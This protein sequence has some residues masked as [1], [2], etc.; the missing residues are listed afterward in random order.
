MSAPKPV[1]LSKL[2]G[3]SPEQWGAFRLN[4]PGVEGLPTP[5]QVGDYTR[6]AILQTAEESGTT[7]VM[8]VALERDGGT[9]DVCLVGNSP[10][11]FQNAALIAAAPALLAELERCREVIRDTHRAMVEDYGDLEGFPDEDSVMAGDMGESA[12]TFGHVR[13]LAALLPDTETP[14]QGDTDE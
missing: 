8:F 10:R 2:K 1:D 6:D 5:Q 14:S 13:R 11:A 12:I 3:F 9:F 4:V 7:D